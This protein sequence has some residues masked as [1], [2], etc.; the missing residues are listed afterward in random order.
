MWE[1]LWGQTLARKAFWTG[2]YMLAHHAKEFQQDG[3]EI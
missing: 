3:E 1:P 2:Y